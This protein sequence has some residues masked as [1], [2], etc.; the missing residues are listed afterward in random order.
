MAWTTPKTWSTNEVVTAANMNTHVR[1]NMSFL[2]SP[3]ACSVQAAVSQSVPTSTHTSL[4]AP[5]ENFDTDAM[6]STVT[7]TSRITFTTAGRYLVSATL[8]FGSNVTGIRILSFFVDATTRYEMVAVAAN[9]GGNTTLSGSRAFS[10]TAGQFVEVQGFQS[11]GGNIDL[12][13][14][15]FTAVLVTV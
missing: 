1:D 11:S 2:G 6:H 9:T 13:L 12:A 10:F 15:D 4:I 3:P 5:T 8:V 14:N 7:N